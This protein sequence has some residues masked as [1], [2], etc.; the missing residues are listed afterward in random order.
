MTGQPGA[1]R[2]VVALVP[3]ESLPAGAL[4]GAPRTRLAL[5]HHGHPAEAAGLALL[6]QDPQRAWSGPAAFAAAAA[7]RLLRADETAW[8]LEPVRVSSDGKAVIEGPLRLSAAALADALEHLAPELAPGV[9]LICGDPGVLVTRGALE[10]PSTA[11]AELLAGRALETFWEGHAPLREV[12]LASRRACQEAGGGATHLVPH[13]PA[14]PL[15]ARP[16]REVWP[17]ARATAAVGA[18]AWARALAALL[19]VDAAPAAPGAEL[20]TAARELASA[21]VVVVLLSDATADL[22]G[23]AAARV[24]VA[25]SEPD[26]DGAVEL[27]VKGAPLPTRARDPLGQSFERP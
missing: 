19:A 23:L 26:A 27:A 7:G 15:A 5:T 13:S 14:G 8:L 12:V 2:L 18:P 17:W 16:L 20:A 4:P 22:A 9:E 21:D 24:L 25:A 3:G 1:G 10:G 11:V 6:G